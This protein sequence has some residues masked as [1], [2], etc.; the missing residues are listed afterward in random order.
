MDNKKK[1]WFLIL[2]LLMFVSGWG[3]L[4]ISRELPFSHDPIEDD[5]TI[6]RI[7]EDEESK[8]KDDSDGEAGTDDQAEKLPT[9]TGLSLKRP[10]ADKPQNN[11]PACMEDCD[12]RTEEKKKLNFNVRDEAGNTWERVDDV[13]IFANK[14]YEG[15]AIIAPESTGVYRFFIVNEE[16]RAVK[17]RIEAREET[18]IKVPMLYRLKCNGSYVSGWQEA[19]EIAFDMEHLEPRKR[20]ILELEW[21]WQSS[22]EDSEIGKKADEVQYHL[23]LRL[24]AEGITS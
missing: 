3:L 13:N 16:S 9:K 24:V 5:T 20:D 2:L 6:Y 15:R 21:K 8:E 18:K 4:S 17:Y 1:R 10:G 7:T 22:D 23:Y 11:I 14:E 12:E 19:H